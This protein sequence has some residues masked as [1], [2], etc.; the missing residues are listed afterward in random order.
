MPVAST[1]QI[2]RTARRCRERNIIVPTFAQQRDPSLIPESI[3][4]E[5][6]DIGRWDVHPR[7]LFRVSWKNDPE[8]PGFDGVNMLEIP[9]A[10][11]GVP[12]RIFGLV[13]KYFPTGSH[14]VGATFG[15]LVPRL[16]DGSFDP[17]QNKAVW[18]STGNYCRGGAYIAALLACESV[19]ILPEEMSRERFEWLEEI[20]SEIIATKGCESNVKEIFD[21]CW[22]LKQERDDVVVFNQFE[23]FGNSRWHYAV[24]AEAIAEVL[25]DRLG[26]RDQ[27]SA[28]ISAT[29]S[30]GTLAA[31]DRL[32]EIYPTAKIV[33]TEALQCPTLL[34]CGFGGHRIEGIGDKHVPWIHNVRNTDLVMGIDDADPMA[35]IRLFNE[36][37]G[38]EFLARQQID[39]QIVSRL[40]CLG[41]S[42]IANL[43]GAIKT[44]KWFELDEH[45]VLVTVF[46]DSMDLYASRLAEANAA[47]GPYTQEQAAVDF[48]GR[49]QRAGTDHIEE[50]G[51]RER[52][53]IHNLKYFT[54]VEQQGKQVEELNA[55]WNQYRDY[56]PERFCGSDRID[57]QIEA[58]NQL[59]QKGA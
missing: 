55:Q 29:G 11:S 52:K 5:L 4:Q 8:S 21:K 15:C 34:S 46:T 6:N 58:F 38:Q 54:W 31:G 53:R 37:A 33:A 43:L 19:A 12:A 18:P 14:K 59:A 13:G 39:P 17:T 9:P 57:R 51:Y 23:E 24:T 1:K 44:A 47:R 48:H 16:I 20:G 30:A 50:L 2:E 26:S 41:I 35:L 45:D 32:K 27:F 25:A 56:W 49:L 7:N 40:P 3:Q 36:P 28:Y 42:S 10:L 22:E